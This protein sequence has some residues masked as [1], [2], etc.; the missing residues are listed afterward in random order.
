MQK[1]K[2]PNKQNK[3]LSVVK[4]MLASQKSTKNKW[5][6]MAYSL[7]STEEVQVHTVKAA[8]PNLCFPCPYV[9]TET[10]LLEIF[11]LDFLKSPVFSDPEHYYHVDK[12]KMNS[13][14]YLCI[15]IHNRA[16]NLN[17]NHPLIPL[18]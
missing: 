17:K 1:N 7:R 6:K 10:E 16:K 11:N 14:R 18:H 8:T 4:E 12:K 3:I 9:S 15:T 5:H 13:L 2:K